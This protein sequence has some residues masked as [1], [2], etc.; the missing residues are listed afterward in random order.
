MRDRR[1]NGVIGTKLSTKFRSDYVEHHEF[2]TFRTVSISITV[3]N[4]FS[5]SPDIGAMKLPAAPVLRVNQSQLIIRCQLRAC[6][7]AY[8]EVNPSKHIDRLLGGLLQGIG[9]SHV[10]LSWYAGPSSCGRQL[11]RCLFKS[12]QPVDSRKSAFTKGS[13]GRE[14]PSSYYNCV[15]SMAH[16]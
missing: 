5:E 16:L 12:I 15:G 6:H 14:L 13:V 9:L 4:A 1:L 8:N 10:R 7:T 2:R 11:F 3:L